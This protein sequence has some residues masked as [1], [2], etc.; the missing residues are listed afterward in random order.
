M[1][2]Y[3]ANQLSGEGSPCESLTGGTTYTL[4]LSNPLSGS[5]YFTFETKR[6]N[7]GFYNGS[8]E[9]AG[10]VINNLSLVSSLI[11]F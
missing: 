3:T 2:N 11:S 7:D 9:S 4:T 6:D 10:G 1:A 8:N 5:A